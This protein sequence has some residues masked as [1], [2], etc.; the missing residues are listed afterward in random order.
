MRLEC[1]LESRNLPEFCQTKKEETTDRDREVWNFIE[2]ALDSDPRM[3]YLNLLGYEPNKVAEKINQSL[4][5]TKP[6]N[7]NR[8][9]SLGDDDDFINEGLSKMSTSNGALD[10]FEFIAAKAEEEAEISKP[11]SI[12]VDDSGPGLLS[13]ALLTGNLNLAV[14]FCLEQG[15]LADALILAMQGGPELLQEAQKKYI[16]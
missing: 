6:A 4:R 5:T 2:A 10:E 3:K 12:C 13:R 8:R 15:R 16:F 9:G 1:T 11:F 14:E 7:A